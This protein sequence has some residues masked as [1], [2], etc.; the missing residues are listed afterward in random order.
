MSSPAGDLKVAMKP[1]HLV[2]MSLGSA[3]GAGLF[4]GS[5]EGIATAGPA[6]LL[7]YVISVLFHDGTWTGWGSLADF[8]PLVFRIALASFAAYAFGQVMDIFV[9]NRLRQMKAW[10]V[11]PT[12]STF[13]GNA[14]DTVLFFSIAF[15]ASSDPFMAENWPHIALVDYL[16]KLAICTLMFVPAYG[17]LLNVLTRRLTALRSGEPQP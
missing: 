10:W 13:A 12:A 14:L 17:V 16:F 9:F 1:R 15:H 5:G 3:I 7:S 8:Q 11:A 6:V 4:V 2:M